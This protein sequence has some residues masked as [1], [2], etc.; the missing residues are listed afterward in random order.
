M[1]EIKVAPLRA[2]EI[3]RLEEIERDKRV[4]EFL[5]KYK[6][7]PLNIDKVCGFYACHINDLINIIETPEK[8][9]RYDNDFFIRHDRAILLIDENYIAPFPFHEIEAQT[10]ED[11]VLA[12]VIKKAQW[13]VFNSTKYSDQVSLD[14]IV[15]YFE[16]HDEIYEW[17]GYYATE[18]KR[19]AKLMKDYLLNNSPEELVLF[20]FMD[21]FLNGSI[22]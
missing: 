15:K 11:I 14:S 22:R 6:K 10:T 1:E 3:R 13:R 18:I 7:E 4:L 19:I 17:N 8:Y 20:P 5:K 12:K 21:D 16:R 2:Y 9:V